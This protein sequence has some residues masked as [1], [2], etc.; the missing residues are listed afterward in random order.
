MK[1]Q[2]PAFLL[3]IAF[4]ISGCSQSVPEKDQHDEVRMLQDAAFCS[5]LYK[6]NKKGYLALE[7]RSAEGYFQ[8][9]SATVDAHERLS[10]FVSNYAEGNIKESEKHIAISKCLDFYNSEELS[11]FIEGIL[12]K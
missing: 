2:F 11:R 8:L 5:C 12:K 7:D 10:V 4:P 3:L 9:S 1:I 6:A